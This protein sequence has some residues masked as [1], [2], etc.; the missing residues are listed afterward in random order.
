VI[1]PVYVRAHS[2][3]ATKPVVTQAKEIQIMAT[4]KTK[5]TKTTV[6]KPAGAQGLAKIYKVKKQFDGG[7]REEFCKA[8]PKDGASL[9]A[10]AKKAGVDIKRARGYA[11]WLAANGYLTRVEIKGV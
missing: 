7:V 11:Y 1:V 10:I 4:K 2:S 9:E 3:R 5:V 6:T 8:I